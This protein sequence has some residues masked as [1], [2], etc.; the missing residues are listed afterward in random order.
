MND[1]LVYAVCEKLQF[2]QGQGCHRCER[3]CQTPYGE[4]VHGCWGMA[5][6]MIRTVL[7]GADLT[8]AIELRAEAVRG[9]RYCER[10][11]MCSEIRRAALL[12]I[13]PDK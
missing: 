13:E 12:L 6:E 9:L 3:T 4:G 7:M 8:A 1:E 11:A 5:E 2:M 10:E